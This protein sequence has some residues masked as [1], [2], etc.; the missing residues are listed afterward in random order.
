MTT[1]Q[2][3]KLTVKFN[4][5]VS[6][7]EN[8]AAFKLYSHS[9]ALQAVLSVYGKHQAGYN[10][11]TRSVAEGSANINT[12]MGMSGTMVQTHR[13]LRFKMRTEKIA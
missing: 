13:H 4:S 7:L 9:P 6:K 11:Y 10:T 12:K 5:S 3:N 2:T 8:Q 1:E